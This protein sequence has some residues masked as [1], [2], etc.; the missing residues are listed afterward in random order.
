MTNHF[1]RLEPVELSLGGLLYQ[2]SFST[3]LSGNQTSYLQIKTGAVSPLVISYEV[4]SSAEPLK[5][6]AL[7]TPTLTDGTTLVASRNMNRI[8]TTNATTLFYSD[9]TGISGG[10]VLDI[11][12]V[13]AGKGSGAA[14]ESRGAWKLKP[15]TSYVWKIEQLT[16]QATV[17]AGQIVFSEG[18]GT[19]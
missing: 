18:F 2:A 9:P 14:A 1:S 12:I 19:F 7:E 15:N 17:I 4:E 16:N 3:T 11:M 5:V 6:T 13:T 10:T 8:K